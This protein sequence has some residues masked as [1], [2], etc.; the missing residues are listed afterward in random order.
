MY[1]LDANALIQAKNTYYQMKICPGFWEWLE[2]ANGNHVV[3]SVRKIYDEIQAGDDE[4]TTWS[5]TNRE[6]FLEADTTAVASAR[7]LI[8]WANGHEQYTTAAK[9]EFLDSGDLWLIAHAHAHAFTVVTHEVSD[10]KS[11]KAIKIPDACAAHKV[12][13]ENLWTVLHASDM[14]LAFVSP[15]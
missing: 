9:N 13:C 5:D 11:K 8:Q 7:T 10:P 3:A 12:K 15:A 14:R 1:L 4:L 6:F 2:S